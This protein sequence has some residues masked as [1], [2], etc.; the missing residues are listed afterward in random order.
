MRKPSRIHRGL[1]GPRQLVGTPYLADAELRRQYDAEIAPRTIAA[2]ARILAR[3]L[4]VAAGGRALIR[5][6]LDLGAGT[7]AAGRAVRAHCGEDVEVVSVDRVP[8]PGIIVTDLATVAGGVR[9]AGV[10]GRFDL[11]V[12]AH[13]LNELRPDLAWRARLVQAW[14]DELLDP[15]GLLVLVEPALRET[16]RHL[17]FVRDRLVEA[18]LFVVAPCFWQGPCPALGRPRDW[19]HDTA[20][21]H[22]ASGGSRRVD[23]SYLVV[24][25]KTVAGLAPAKVNT[26][27]SPWR[28]V[29][30]PMPD[31][32]RLRLIGCGASGR[33]VLSLLTKH[34]SDENRAFAQAVRG[35]VMTVANAIEAGDGL[36]LDAG[37][38]VIL[39]AGTFQEGGGQ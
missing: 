33:H 17:L 19:C 14:C 25:Q 8:G 13:F 37:A 3:E 29:S 16:S 31:K 18:G 26:F 1:V 28:V 2:L 36:R 23:F 10:R 11:V 38:R 21:S 7:G 9:S 34:R 32:G 12:A 27:A 22:D 30:D 20:P 15:A 6:A 35:D 5:R 24:R 4:P 39:A